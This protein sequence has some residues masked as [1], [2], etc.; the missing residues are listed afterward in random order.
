MFYFL[1]TGFVEP[2]HTAVTV[3]LFP[4]F[5]LATW[6]RPMP[7][8]WRIRPEGPERLRRRAL[9]GQ[10]LM[11]AV[12]LGLFAGGAVVSVVGLTG[13]FV[14]T[15]L[16]FLGTDADRLH[17]VNPRL[18]PF[19]A[20]DRA[21]FGGTLMAAG[22]APLLRLLRAILRRTLSQAGELFIEAAVLAADGHGM[23]LAGRSRTGKTSLLLAS[24]HRYGGHLVA[25]D[26][27]SLL[28]IAPGQVWARG[29]PRS[30]TIR[31]DTLPYLGAAAPA[32]LRAEA[33]SPPGHRGPT[34]T[35]DAGVAARALNARLASHVP[36]RALVLPVF[37]APGED[38]VL[39]RLSARQAT[40]ALQPLLGP[41]D[42][43][44]T[45]LEP[46]I[47]ERPPPPGYAARLAAAV[48]VWR[49][50]HALPALPYTVDRLVELLAVQEQTPCPD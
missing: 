24:L 6:R 50:R 41:C 21:G 31:G 13:V 32:L 8:R 18:L 5:L 47:P 15:D 19:V 25:N 35:L 34:V 17:A 10:L 27:A 30:V 42:P 45:W 3:V 22:V 37:A 20:H 39:R 38:V 2:L 44:E 33:T 4:M 23:A 1:G 12:G 9:V 46:L 49:L 14:P 48:P 29:Y 7:P 26:D 28:P 43:Y 16:T 11:I 40:A 36:L